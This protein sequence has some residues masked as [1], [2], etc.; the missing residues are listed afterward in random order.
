[1]S[2]NFKKPLC[3][4]KVLPT[5]RQQTWS[6]GYSDQKLKDIFRDAERYRYL[7]EWVQELTDIRVAGPADPLYG[8]DL[9]AMVDRE[10]RGTGTR[11]CTRCY[12]SGI[13]ID[14]GETCPECKLVQ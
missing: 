12:Y 9:D 7:R 4:Q 11:I 2:I 8:D 10:I 1:M 5:N 13:F 14:D 6:E 3:Q